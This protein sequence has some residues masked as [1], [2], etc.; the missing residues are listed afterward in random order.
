VAPR[1]FFIPLGL[2]PEEALQG[3]GGEASG[4]SK[5]AADGVKVYLDHVL[6]AI[7]GTAKPKVF[8]GTS[9]ERDNAAV[10]EG[11]RWYVTEGESSHTVWENCGGRWEI[12]PVGVETQWS[13]GPSNV[14]LCESP[15]ASGMAVAFGARGL[16]PAS[17]SN[18]DHAGCVVGVALTS[19]CGGGKV[20]YV[21][22]GLARVP[23][24]LA[25]GTTAWVGLHPG[26]LV[27]RPEPGARFVQQIGAVGLEGLSV[28][29]G[30]FYLREEQ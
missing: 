4:T 15:V 12:I 16:V 23:L 14:G 20:R 1:S 24:D 21:T 6:T 13:S 30:Q 7:H 17:T 25:P 19:A 5:K 10:S 18:L 26:Q 3:L 8:C 11:D 29:L 9:Q 28:A 27:P 22:G 2:T